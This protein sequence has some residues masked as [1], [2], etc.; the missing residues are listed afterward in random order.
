MEYVK[1]CVQKDQTYRQIGTNFKR[2]FP[3]VIRGF[4]GT[5]HSFVLFKQWHKERFPS[6]QH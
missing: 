2:E 4:F 6:G 3:D 5:K 1:G